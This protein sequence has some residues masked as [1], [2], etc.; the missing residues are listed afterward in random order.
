MRQYNIAIDKPFKS[1]LRPRVDAPKEGT[2]LTQSKN[3]K[4]YSGGS[5]YVPAYTRAFNLNESAQIF[6]TSMGIFVLTSTSLY[7]YA[8]PTLTLLLGSLPAGGRWSCADFGKHI[9]FSNGSCYLRSNPST[10]VFTSDITDNV[11][12]QA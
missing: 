9:V 2:F 10:G 6:K 11:Y 12:P 7:S 5:K 8:T 1:G 3:F 4:P